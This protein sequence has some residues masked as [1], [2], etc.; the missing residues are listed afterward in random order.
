MLRVRI[1][2]IIDMIFVSI[3][4]GGCYTLGKDS[5]S[6]K[7][8]RNRMV[9]LLGVFCELNATTRQFGEQTSF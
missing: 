1:G 6:K 3:F 4:S 9:S 5:C 7:G 2:R 8:N